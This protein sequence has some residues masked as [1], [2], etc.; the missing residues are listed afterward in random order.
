MEVMP[1]KHKALIVVLAV[2]GWVIGCAGPLSLLAI[3]LLVG[4][5]V[6]LGVRRYF[7]VL[8]IVLLTSPVAVSAGLATRDYVRGDA[9]LLRGGKP[10]IDEIDD[11]TGLPV[12]STG[13]SLWDFQLLWNGSHNATL[14]ALS[15]V[16]GP[17]PH[18]RFVAP[19][20][21]VR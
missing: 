14:R 4:F 13:C 8:A 16:F 1:L 3:P 20:H 21:A 12:L 5:A 9:C 6:W 10:P 7:V 18:S 19:A 15:N 11:D 17:K 2:L